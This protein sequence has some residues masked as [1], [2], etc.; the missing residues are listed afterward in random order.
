MS[1]KNNNFTLI[2]LL[3]VIAIISILAS[4]LLPA[5]NRARSVAK[6]I[7]CVNNLRELGTIVTLYADNNKEYF[8]I[9]AQS[10]YRGLS[11]NTY[12][13]GYII[14]QGYLKS[15]KILNCPE[16]DTGG[17]DFSLTPSMAANNSRF[18]YVN[19]GINYNIAY[20]GKTNY[21]A[22]RSEIKN[23]SRVI[24]MVDSYRTNEPTRGF[25]MAWYIYTAPGATGGVDA[26][27]LHSA[28]VQWGDGHVS[29]EKSKVIG[30]CQTY[31]ASNN[32]YMFPPF[33]NGGVLN[34]NNNYWDLK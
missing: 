22:K 1:K 34:D 26:R 27:H 11:G 3:V 10:N 2:E 9:Y 20:A 8:P 23:V 28:N 13:P 33:S 15:G 4:M 31:S 5:L 29:S 7:K 12:W 14:N 19:Y 21:S 30:F 32:P 18:C 16:K 25:Y 17:V 24:S 6:N